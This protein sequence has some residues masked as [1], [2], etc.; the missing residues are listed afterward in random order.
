MIFSD[1][2]TTDQHKQLAVSGKTQSQSHF[3]SMIIIIIVLQLLYNLSFPYEIVRVC[4]CCLDSWF[5]Y[6]IPIAFWSRQ[7]RP[8]FQEN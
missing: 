5:R 6:L 3:H 1:R 4:A 8:F 7:I 2:D